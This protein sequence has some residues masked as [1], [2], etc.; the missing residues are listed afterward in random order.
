MAVRSRAAPDARCLTAVVPTLEK[1]A[2]ARRFVTGRIFIRFFRGCFS[3]HAFVLLVGKAA[4][5]IVSIGS[6]AP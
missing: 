2:H 1:P 4:V 6:I 3:K 5:N